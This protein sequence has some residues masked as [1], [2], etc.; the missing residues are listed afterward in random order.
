MNF[1]QF[2]TR[3]R[4]FQSNG[5]LLHLSAYYREYVWIGVFSM[6]ANVLMLT[7]TIYMLQLYGRVMKS[8]N[9]MTLLIVSLFMV[10]FFL[11][12]A[13]AEW[14]RSRL[15]V[16]VGVRLDE[17]INGLVFT[18]S[19]RAALDRRRPITG[20]AFS[21]LANLRQFLT[22]N[23]L[24]AFFDVPWTPV[25][26]AFIFLLNPILGWLSILFAVI[27]L[28]MT[29]LT[30]WWSQQEIQNASDAAT[31]SV[32]FAKAKLRAAESIHAMG[33]T[34][35]LRQRWSE[36]HEASLEKNDSA[37]EHQHRLQAF[38]KF[39]RYSLQSLTLGAGA[40]M[41]IDG[42]L[43]VG[44]MIAANVLMSRALQPLDLVVATWKPFIQARAAFQRLDELFAGFS[45]ETPHEPERQ[46]PIGELRFEAVSA[47]VPGRERPILDNIGLMIPAGK[48]TVVLGPSGSG[49]STFARC[50]AGIWP[51]REGR[52]LIDGEP[53]ESWDRVA[54]G[55]HIGYL[56]QDVEL[57]DGTIA[58]NISRFSAIDPEKVVEAAKRTGIHDMIL[59]FPNGYDT[60][61]G[62][63]GGLLSG[64]QRQRLALA[65]AIYGNPVIIVLDEP[66]AN[67]DEAGERALLQ[68]V[69]QLRNQRRTVLVITHR[70]GIIGAADFI[71]LMKGGRIDRFG[72]KNEIIVSKS[73]QF[74]EVPATPG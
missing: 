64:G 19:F 5:L 11:M 54:L 46:E 23:G 72:P 50:L 17:S 56:P 36:L 60:G 3:S 51:G 1:K 6:V 8:G 68:T 4:F 27:Q 30:H 2:L 63:A 14:L 13:F 66:N 15:L 45:T 40:L 26:I 57:F 74:E 59:R 48:V 47:R 33:M 73:A 29:F 28:V 70:P 37:A 31:A 67:L 61:I 49:K 32:Q 18:S 39:V 65:R 24:I 62:E 34:A 16:R 58:E 42:K 21:D 10:F 69:V 35:A 25:Y 20:D 38:T 53:I 12:M 7:P 9:E 71:L 43:H 41:V 55:P 44:S 22:S 52:V